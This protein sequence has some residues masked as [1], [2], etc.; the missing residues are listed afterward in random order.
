M[1]ALAVAIVVTCLGTCLAQESPDTRPEVAAVNANAR[2]YEA[3]Y[4]KGD[5]KALA[6]FFA[7]DAEYTS[8]DGRTF[9]GRGEIEG[10]MRAASVANKG[11]KLAIHVESVRLLAPDI[12]SEKGSTTVT[13]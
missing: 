2:A 13:T 7:E 9:S 3:A 10:V 4:A 11:S 5:V 6:A 12:V 8:D 1:K